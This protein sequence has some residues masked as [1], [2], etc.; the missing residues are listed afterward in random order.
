M[1]NNNYDNEGFES[2]SA[3][4]EQGKRHQLKLAIDF[5]SVKD[6][7]V[8]ATLS[9]NYSFKLLQNVHSFSSA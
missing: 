9:I 1:S 7:R 4:G 5:L 8:S 3:D 2:E 6:M